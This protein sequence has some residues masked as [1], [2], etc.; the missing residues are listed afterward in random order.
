MLELAQLHRL[1][2]VSRHDLEMESYH[3]HRR[4]GLVVSVLCWQ[5]MLH[6]R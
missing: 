3:T 6:M 2:M 1:V 4:A 5:C